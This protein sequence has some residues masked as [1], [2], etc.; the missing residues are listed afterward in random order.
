MQTA[1]HK[2]W[3]EPS[4]ARACLFF[5]VARLS[6]LLTLPAMVSGCLIDDPPAYTQ[7]KRTP[8]R[9]AYNKADPLLD[10][11]ITVTSSDSIDFTIPV[12]S[13]DA[14]EE[15]RAKLILD[16]K[17]IVDNA[18]LPPSTLDDSGRVIRTT[19]SPAFLMFAAALGPGCHLFTLRVAHASSLPLGDVPPT[20]TEDLA[21]AYWWANVNVGEA[22][23][24]MLK[25]CPEP[26][27]VPTTLP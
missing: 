17:I 8:P 10:Q 3:L 20:D 24:G 2:S 16:G 26:S 4:R 22:D 5:G 21:E 12:A 1:T 23:A 6:L 15:L 9:L 27:R 25:D 14:G 13:E 18:S 7:P 11:I 19:A